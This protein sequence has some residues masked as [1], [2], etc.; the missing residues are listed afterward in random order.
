S[1]KEEGAI[2]LFGE[3]YGD[4]VR[5]IDIGGFSKELCGGTHLDNTSKIGFFKIEIEQSIGS[6]LR[7]I[8][9]VTREKA[10]AAIKENENQLLELQK[11]L[12]TPKKNIIAKIQQLISE[13]ENLKREFR[14]LWK[15]IMPFRVDEI[16]KNKNII[17]NTAVISSIVDVKD[18]KDLREIGDLIKEKLN[19]GIII[20]G[21]KLEEDKI[22][23][24]VMV[25]DDLINKGYDAGK[26]I[27]PFATAV[28][29]KGGG[30]R[31]FAQAGGTGLEHLKKSFENI[32]E[33]IQL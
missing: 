3:K 2:A 23:I 22:S 9:A 16:I 30:K 32:E 13:N 5:M 33:N 12:D 17:K 1:A 25:T 24:I 29:G 11:L 10:R 26:I 27:K 21:A 15:E 20:L 28:N 4:T 7:R 18:K 19:S 14:L 8:E 6:G 31:N